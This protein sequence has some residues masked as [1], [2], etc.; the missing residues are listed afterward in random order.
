MSIRALIVTLLLATPA[1]AQYTC[2]EIRAAYKQYGRV[3]LE[4]WGVAS[5]VTPAQRRAVIRCI[6][7]KRKP[8]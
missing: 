5:G 1:Q 2:D 8:R 3:Q 7:G 4:A 6:R